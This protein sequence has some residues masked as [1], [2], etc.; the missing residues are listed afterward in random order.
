MDERLIRAQFNGLSEP[1]KVEIMKSLAERYQMNFKEISNF[2]RWEKSSATG[3]FE[4]DGADFVFVPGDAV[5]LGWASFSEGLTADSAEELREVYEEFEFDGTYEEFLGSMLTSPHTV[6]IMP[7]LAEREPRGIYG[8]KIPVDDPRVRP[9]WREA[10][11]RAISGRE[12]L[13]AFTVLD[14]VRFTRTGDI[15]KAE[16]YSDI[17]YAGLLENLAIDGYSLPTADEWAYLCGGGCQ[18]LFPWGDGIIQGLRLQHFD[19]APFTLY[20]PNFF[21]IKIAFD[22][23]KSELIHANSPMSMGGDG[24]V[25]I[26]GGLGKFLGYLPCSPYYK[27]QAVEEPMDGECLFRRIIRI[28]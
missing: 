5:T 2:S 16:I 4:K 14:K 20:K 28:E 24:G 12:T 26:C 22:P 18:T 8:D 17:T 9:E 21:G 19:K 10:L 23:Y 7:M 27:P 11:T 13:T 25:N 1:E 15:W 3:I 6:E